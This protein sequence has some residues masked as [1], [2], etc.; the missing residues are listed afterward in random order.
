MH[1]GVGVGRTGTFAICA[2][3]ALGLTSDDASAAVNAAGSKAERP[4]QEDLIKS[5][6]KRVAAFHGKAV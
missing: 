5:L 2:L 4:A 3:M 1:C 6:A